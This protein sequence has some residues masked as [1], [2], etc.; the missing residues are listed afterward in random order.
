M[1]A[2]APADRLPDPAVALARGLAVFALPPGGRRPEPGWQQA[3]TAEAE[4]V[5]AAWRP[6]DNI[7]VGCRASNVVGIDLDRND[8]GRTALPRSAR[9]A[10]TGGSRGR[11][12]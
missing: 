12:R 2:S 10:P 6:G 1:T 3:A 11:A 8:D 5:L 7:G 4:V 9:C